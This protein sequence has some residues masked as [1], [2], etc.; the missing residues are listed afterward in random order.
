MDILTNQFTLLTFENTHLAVPLSEVVTIE[1]TRQMQPDDSPTR[2]LG[3]VSQGGNTYPVYV[4]SPEFDLLTQLPTQ[5]L[6]CVCLRAED[7]DAELALACD[8]TMP[9]R[10]E[11]SEHLEVL[12]ECM[13]KAETPVQGLLNQG[14]RLVLFSTT[15]ALANYINQMESRYEC[16]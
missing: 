12:P 3:S 9:M 1:R 5:R 14:Q 7:G 10:L 11:Q 15:G 13:Q 8:T 6:F 4:L 2:M 16:A